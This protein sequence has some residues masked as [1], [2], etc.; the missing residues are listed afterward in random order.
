MNQR[1]AAGIILVALSLLFGASGLLAE[2]YSIPTSTRLVHGEIELTD[3]ET[4]KFAVL[5]G[6]MLKLRN[7]EEGYFLGFSPTIVDEANLEVRFA[8]FEITE[9]GP[10]LH[11]LRQIES[12]E[13][14]KTG[15]VEKIH[16]EIEITGIE[17]SGL[18]KA[19]LEATQ[20]KLAVRSKIPYKPAVGEK[21]QSP[22]FAN[23]DS[24]CV[25]CGSTTS[26]GCAV[27]MSCGSCCTGSCCGGGGG[28]P[29]TPEGEG[30]GNQDP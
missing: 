16:T 21:P 1:P 7:S 29:T 2:A 15:W 25:T 9:H 23:K 19:E 24:C 20:A 12:I 10:G 22:G 4:V 27:T 13:A 3:G 11:A 18:S 14:A 6:Q 30:P 17:E 26:C 28:G 8:V 5:E